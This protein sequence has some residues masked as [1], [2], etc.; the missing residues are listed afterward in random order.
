MKIQEN[1]WNIKQANKER[2]EK[3]KHQMASGE[4]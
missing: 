2:K 1:Y 3:E 4:I